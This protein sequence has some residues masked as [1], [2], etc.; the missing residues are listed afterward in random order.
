[1]FLINP[2]HRRSLLALSRSRLQLLIL[3][4]LCTPAYSQIVTAPAPLQPTAVPSLSVW[5]T[6]LLS[7]VLAAL[8][9]R[10]LRRRST[11][12]SIA[13]GTVAV[14]AVL[15]TVTQFS[16]VRAAVQL[17]FSNPEGEE[18]EIAVFP[19]I[20]R[21]E[22]VSFEIAKFTNGSNVRL[23]LESVTLPQYDQCFP[24]GLESPLGA[25]LEVMGSAPL[26]VTGLEL[27]PGEQC[28]LDVHEVCAEVAEESQATLLI[29]PQQITLEAPGDS[30]DVTITNSSSSPVPAQ[31]VSLDLGP[32]FSVA[33]TCPSEL[34][35]GESCTLRVTAESNE[36]SAN[37]VARGSNTFAAAAPVNPPP[38]PPPAPPTTEDGQRILLGSAP[39]PVPPPAPG[40]PAPVLSDGLIPTEDSGGDDLYRGGSFEAYDGFLRFYLINYI[41]DE[42]FLTQSTQGLSITHSPE[43]NVIT[44]C[45][46]EL[47]PFEDCGLV[48]TAS[49]PGNYSIDFAAL[50]AQP[51]SVPIEV[52]EWVPDANLTED[53]LANVGAPSTCSPFNFSF[54]QGIVDFLPRPQLDA[55]DNATLQTFTENGWTIRSCG[56]SYLFLQYAAGNSVPA[57]V[58]GL[59]EGDFEPTPAGVWSQ[60]DSIDP[61]KKTTLTDTIVYSVQT[62]YEADALLPED[63]PSVLAD[64]LNRSYGGSLRLKAGYH[65]TAEI[66]LGGLLADVVGA[67]HYPTS[68]IVMMT[69]RELPPEQLEGPTLEPRGG[70]WQQAPGEEEEEEEPVN[71]I[72]L[73]HADLWSDSAG[74]QGLNLLDTTVY[75]DSENTFGFW[76]VGSFETNPV[77]LFYRGPLKVSRNPRTYREAQIGFGARDITMDAYLRFIAAYE[78]R[79]PRLAAG[80]VGAFDTVDDFFTTAISP[81]NALPLDVVAIR[82]DALA[83]FV[84]S[85]K[86]G[87]P[88]PDFSVFN[89]VILG[90]DAE[91][92][93]GVQGPHVELRGTAELFNQEMG[94][95]EFVA[96]ESG[97]SGKV[98]GDPALDLGAVAGIS[99]GALNPMAELEFFGSPSGAGMVLEG[100]FAGGS[101]P[102]TNITLNFSA[103]SVNFALPGDCAKPLA[104]AASASLPPGSRQN[105]STSNVVFTP[106]ASLPDPADFIACAEDIY[107]L[108]RDGVVYAF[109]GAVELLEF[110]NSLLPE[111][112][113][114][115]L[116]IDGV[117]FAGGAIIDAPEDI[118]NV[119]RDLPGVGTAIQTA[120][121]LADAQARAEAAAR[122]AQRAA[123]EAARAAQAAAEQAAAAVAQ[124]VQLVSD[125][126][127]NPAGALGNALNNVSNEFRSLIGGSSGPTTRTLSVLSNQGF[128]YDVLDVSVGHN[129]ISIN[130]WILD[131]DGTPWKEINDGRSRFYRS[132]RTGLP[133]GVVGRRIEADPN[134]GA[135]MVTNTGEL[136][137]IMDSASAWNKSNIL[138]TDVGVGGGNIWVTSTEPLYGSYRIYRAP[139]AGRGQVR[140]NWQPINGAAQRIDV[141]GNGRAWVINNSFEVWE[142]TA[143]GTFQFRSFLAADVTVNANSRAFVASLDDKGY[144]GGQLYFR[145]NGIWN[146]MNA[147]GVAIG[148]GSTSSFLWANNAGDLYLGCCLY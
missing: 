55:F 130:T 138:A 142:Y 63:V 103:N 109:N 17:A 53:Q 148:A 31:N 9:A 83:S 79:Y 106:T 58:L 131:T 73:A 51:T 8:G 82:N 99:L 96:S 14:S 137:A 6:A 147:S 19:L 38:P 144:G 121:D 46:A 42:N 72:E 41:R 24:S 29:E 47:T 135:Y 100:Q 60:L 7:V 26:C 68:N 129:P 36:L 122:E 59:I 134:G 37:I 1:M 76:G 80:A 10:I 3:S 39:T 145:E 13:I 75:Y 146:P 128:P 2:C 105:F 66:T 77:S 120:I 123:E 25:P 48:V 87:D 143:G 97:A 126:I 94:S 4:T 15:A 43:L 81:M 141:G 44:D 127:S 140:F 71:Y 56:S 33:G 125:F 64:V 101:L 20:E 132:V 117:K 52:T 57:R 116:G 30:L 5:A 95:L 74:I 118:L 67:M 119:G 54:G 49:E 102:G 70:N 18:V 104:I 12:S 23:R 78:A 21:G 115:R 50:N 28:A 111:N 124:A 139:Y 114:T 27:N 91:S 98:T 112:D 65:A 11:L 69:G 32:E 93:D 110:G 61:A 92:R 45:P 88:F 113:V 107:F 86:S 90:P 89:M 108:V 62:G 133:P 84:G 136:Y 34:L 85:F 22:V 16:S 40:E 35:P